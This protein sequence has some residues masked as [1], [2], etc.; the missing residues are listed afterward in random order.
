MRMQQAGRRFALT[1]ALVALLVACSMP[2]TPLHVEVEAD[3]TPKVTLDF[4]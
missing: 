1:M 3:K 2:P 4:N